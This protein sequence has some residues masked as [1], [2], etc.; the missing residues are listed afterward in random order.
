MGDIV[1]EI[2]EWVS[3]KPVTIYDTPRKMRSST[4]TRPS[5]PAFGRR[6]VGALPSST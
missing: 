3:E 1:D 6:R 5:V 2:L 4:S